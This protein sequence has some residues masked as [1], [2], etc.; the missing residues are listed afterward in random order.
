MST[1]PSQP[2]AD[3]READ[4]PGDA[5]VG[6]SDATPTESLPADRTPWVEA[7][8]GV[9]CLSAVAATAAL[10][11]GRSGGWFLPAVCL[12]VGL[13]AAGFDAATG[14]V[15]NPITYT[16]VLIGLLGNGL[17]MILPAF[18]GARVA[19]HWLGAAGLAQSVYGLLVL[20]GIGVIGVA[21]AG[22]GG[23]D[24]KLLAA[25]GALLGLRQ[26]IN[27]LLCGVAVAVAYA[28]VNLLL[29]GRLNATLRVAAGHLLSLVYLRELPDLREA[30]V[31]GSRRTIPLAVPLLIGLFAPHLPP[32]RSAV[33]W[34]TAPG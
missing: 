19:E 15:P 29:S 8:A 27:V 18:G 4:A 16:A 26:S 25:F 22:M 10:L 9:L 1:A 33:Q 20:G 13:L 31:R 2:A 24:M 28:V 17:A 21:V 11:M 14:R 5:A 12:G 32:V 3:L 23:G 6:A 30:G 7:W 34:L